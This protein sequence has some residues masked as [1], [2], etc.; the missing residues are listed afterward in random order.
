VARARRQAVA[1]NG[2]VPLTDAQ[3]QTV[4]TAA[5]QSYKES[6]VDP[7]MR[8]AALAQRNIAQALAQ[9]QLNQTPTAEQAA[10]V[11][12]DLVNHRLA[13]EQLASLFSTRGREGLAFK[14]AVSSEAKKLDPGFNWEESA[15]NYQLVKS[16]NFQTTVRYMDSVQE[17][18]PRLLNNA[19]RLGRG[20]ITS[21]NQ[22]ANMAASQFSDTDLKRLKTDAVLV[23]DEVAKLLAG[24]GSGSATSDAKLKQGMD[25]I[26]AADSVPA[27]AAGLD[28]INN[29][30]GFRRKALTRGT[31][32]EGTSAGQQTRSAP[33]AV[34]AAPALPAKGEKRTFNGET[35]MWDG[36]TW[37]PL[38]AQ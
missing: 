1:S 26:N 28:E 38:K 25:L 2:G 21:L 7:Q 13:P 10:S 5:L 15:A 24:G 37:Q 9:L 8:D 20:P 34:V 35:R 19:S 29:L 14:L 16:P 23:G 4:D 12:D 11:A 33:P 30:I 3:L 32:L 18:I 27:M 31:Y 6:N 22:L 17:S 36:G